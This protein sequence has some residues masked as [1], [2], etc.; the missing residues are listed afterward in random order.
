MAVRQGA[1]LLLTGVWLGVLAASWLAATAS[2]RGVDRVLG[3]DMRPE[4]GARLSGLEAAERRMTLRHVAAEINR[5]M[6]RRLGVLQLGVGLLAL[7]AAWPGVAARWLLGAAV[8]IAISQVVL[9]S[10]IESFGRSLDFL[11]RPL[12][13]DMG[14]RFGLLHACFLLLDV[15]KMALL[16]AAGHALARRPF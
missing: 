15:G 5:W 7:A 8:A 16:F 11:P 10:A 14:R 2:F 13:P 4:L 3:T 6:F 1:A 12:P 9:G